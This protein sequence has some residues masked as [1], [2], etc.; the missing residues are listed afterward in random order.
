MSEVKGNTTKI[1][2]ALLGCGGLIL[3]LGVIGG[4]YYFSVSKDIRPSIETNNVQ[5][6]NG[7]SKAAPDVGDGWTQYAHAQDCSSSIP[8]LVLSNF[9]MDHPSEFVVRSVC[10]DSNYVTLGHLDSSGDMKIL[11]GVGYA[12]LKLVINDPVVEQLMDSVQSAFETKGSFRP[13]SESPFEARG[14]KLIARQQMF[15]IH[16]RDGAYRVGDYIN[17]VILVPGPND[18]GLTLLVMY[19]V[20]SNIENTKV[21]LEELMTRVVNSIEL[22]E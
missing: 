1:I 22:P 2:I 10:Q 13:L 7:D 4:V 6:N 21:E 18:H 14:T 16:T 11:V 19:R 12:N 8:G 9:T 20:D 17:Q 15:K 3:F 5:T